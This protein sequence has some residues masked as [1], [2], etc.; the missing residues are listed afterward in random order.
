M[1]TARISSTFKKPTDTAFAQSEY[2]RGTLLEVAVGKLSAC[3]AI[4]I[5]AGTVDIVRVCTDRGLMISQAL[6][7]TGGFDPM[8]SLDVVC[9]LSIV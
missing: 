8:L 9:K 6:L 3:C 4:H 2:C 1:R 5:E 7:A